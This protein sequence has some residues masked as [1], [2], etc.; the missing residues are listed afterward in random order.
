MEASYR[1]KICGELLDKDEVVLV[2]IGLD[3]ERVNV[4]ELTAGERRLEAKTI[5]GGGEI[6]VVVGE[7]EEEARSCE[8][9]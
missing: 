3:F 4:G 7:D 1:I 6:V 2:V 8:V 9:S 5:R